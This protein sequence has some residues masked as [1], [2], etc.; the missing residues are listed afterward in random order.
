[1]QSVVSQTARV[2]GNLQVPLQDITQ[3]IKQ[4]ITQS[5]KQSIC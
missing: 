2:D 4:D 1:M 3:S 5:I